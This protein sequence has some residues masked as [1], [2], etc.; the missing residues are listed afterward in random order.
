MEKLTER[1][2]NRKAEELNAILESSSDGILVLDR[3]DHILHYNTQFLNLWELPRDAEYKTYD[4]LS[5][6]RRLITGCDC[7]HPTKQV[8]KTEICYLKTGLILERYARVLTE[9]EHIDGILCVYRDVTEKVKKEERLTEIANTDFLTGLN[10]RRYFAFLAAYEFRK[11]KGTG[12]SL[13]LLMIDI[14]DFKQINDTYGHDAG[15]RALKAFAMHLRQCSRRSDIIGRYGGEEFC[16]LLPYTDAETA[17]IIAE[18][19]RLHC[20]NSGINHQDKRI[21]WTISIGVANTGDGAATMEALIKHADV[22][23]YQAKQEGRNRVKAYCE[24]ASKRKSTTE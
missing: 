10:N 18:R 11:A 19:M 1:T 8:Q 2:L 20:E 3:G 23:C 6:K 21:S 17:N 14:D 24:P 9:Q 12:D 13:A 15:D 5:L 16:V 7:V 22:A 4:D